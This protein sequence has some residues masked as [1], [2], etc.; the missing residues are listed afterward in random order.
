MNLPWSISENLRGLQGN[1]T[2]AVRWWEKTLRKNPNAVEAHSNLG[3]YLAMQGRMAEAREH[4][5]S[6]GPGTTL[7]FFRLASPGTG[8]GIPSSLRAG[9]EKL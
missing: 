2:E 7:L 9:S 5:A 1:H 4:F 3:S 8:R 6:C